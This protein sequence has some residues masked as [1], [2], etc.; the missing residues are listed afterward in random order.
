MNTFRHLSMAFRG[1]SRGHA[2]SRGIGLSD[3]NE[4]IARVPLFHA[5]HHASCGGGLAG[6]CERRFFRFGSPMVPGEPAL[7]TLRR[8]RTTSP[9]YYTEWVLC[10]T[11]LPLPRSASSS[12][13]ASSVPASAASRPAPIFTSVRARCR[14]PLVHPVRSV[15]LPQPPRR[16][17]SRRR[18]PGPPATPRAP[19]AAASSGTSSRRS[20]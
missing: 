15:H 3:L 9:I 10:T 14:A 12:A 2:T 6:A 13:A 5:H 17:P 7:V 18:E 8:P 16:S 1:M 20:P 19:T 4:T 11:G